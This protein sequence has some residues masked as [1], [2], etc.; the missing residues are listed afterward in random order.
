M[1]PAEHTFQAIE[2]IIVTDVALMRDGLRHALGA[3]TSMRVVDAAATPA[4]AVAAVTE[5]RS[6]VVLLDMSC[7]SWL[8]TVSALHGVAPPPCVVAFSVGDDEEDI[9]TCVE[10]GVVGFV[11]K[12]GTAADLV[13]ACQGALRGE[14]HC[15]PRIAARL[16][17]R[18][19]AR[20]P[21]AGYASPAPL[22]SPRETEIVE[23]IDHGLSNKA[24][25]RHLSIELATVK[26]HVH[27]ILR[28]LH[29]TTRGE[30]ATVLRKT[31]SS[32]RRRLGSASSPLLL[33]PG[34]VM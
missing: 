30:A 15:C 3:Y 10:L 21:L 18:F 11:P 23:L 12:H 17:R 25:A 22:L 8:E 19:A 1:K 14:A 5:R 4:E 16:F 26:N 28:K 7:A 34:P 31:A 33:S 6:A 9:L 32:A 20:A 29:V 24:I 27:N 2:S 13:A